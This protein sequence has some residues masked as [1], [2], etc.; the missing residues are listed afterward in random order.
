MP[1][2]LRCG[3]EDPARQGQD[4]HQQQRRR[5][6]LLDAAPTEYGLLLTLEQE[7][8]ARLEF[9]PD[10]H[11]AAIHPHGHGPA[12]LDPGPQVLHMLGA[13]LR[14]VHRMQPQGRIETLV[15][16][17][18]RPEVLPAEPGHSR[19]QQPSH[20]GRPGIGQPAAKR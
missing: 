13:M 19:D 6:L 16:L 8:G 4:Q 2:L 3:R 9:V 5:R 11:L 20:T 1:L 18:E 12:S 14:Q 15:R 7:G 10:Q 17:A